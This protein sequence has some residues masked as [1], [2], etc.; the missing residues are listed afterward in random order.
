MFSISEERKRIVTSANNH[1]MYAPCHRSC[2]L[3]AFKIVEKS[4]TLYGRVHRYSLLMSNDMYIIIHSP[5]YKMSKIQAASI[6]FSFV[7]PVR[8]KEKVMMRLPGFTSFYTGGSIQ[9]NFV[10]VNI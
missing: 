2:P 1:N 5:K 8:T 6:M 3:F 4:D 10:D 7:K 9:N